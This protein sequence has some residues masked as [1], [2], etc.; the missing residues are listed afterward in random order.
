MVLKPEEDARDVI[1]TA[2][3]A[4]RA[5]INPTDDTGTPDAAPDSGASH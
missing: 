4:L 3:G 5:M 2:L 1:G